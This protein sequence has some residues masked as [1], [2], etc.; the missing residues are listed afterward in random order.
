MADFTNLK[1]NIKSNIK[2]N[3]KQ[4]VTG[5]IL[6]EQMID[7]VDQMNETFTGELTELESE[8]RIDFTPV[9][10]EKIEG[11]YL[12]KGKILPELGYCYTKT[13][14]AKAGDL[15][16]CQTNPG[17]FMSAIESYIDEERTSVLSSISV[18][19]NEL[20]STYYLATQDCFVSFSG[21]TKTLIVAKSTGAYAKLAKLIHNNDDITQLVYNAV[22]IPFAITGYGI[23]NRGEIVSS[24]EEKTTG[25][26]FVG[27]ATSVVISVVYPSNNVAFYDFNKKLITL[28][29]GK[30]TRETIEVPSNAVYMAVGDL[31]SNKASEV[32]INIPSQYLDLANHSV[33]HG[34][35]RKGTIIATSTTLSVSNLDNSNPPA[36]PIANAKW[37]WQ[38]AYLK[39]N[40]AL[41]YYTDEIQTRLVPIL[42]GA[43]Y[44][45]KGRF[46]GDAAM[47]FYDENS[48]FISGISARDAGSNIITNLD[49]VTPKNAKYASFNCY[50]SSVG[51]FEVVCTETYYATGQNPLLQGSKKECGIGLVLETER[52]NK[53][54]SVKQK[55]VSNVANSDGVIELIK[56]SCDNGVAA[57]LQYR[58]SKALDKNLPQKENTDRENDIYH[59]EFPMSVFE[60]YFELKVGDEIKETWILDGMKR[61]PFIKRIPVMTIR[62]IADESNFENYRNLRLFLESNGNVV[63]RLL[64]KN[65]SNVIYQKDINTTDD[66]SILF[67][68]LR[69]ELQ[70]INGLSFDVEFG[71]IDGVSVNELVATKSAGLPFITQYSDNCKIDGTILLDN[72]PVFIEAVDNEVFEI[73][74]VQNNGQIRFFVEGDLLT[75]IN[76]EINSCEYGAEGLKVLGIDCDSY[77][78]GAYSKRPIIKGFTCHE[79]S[80]MPSSKTSDSANHVGNILYLD[81]MLRNK[82]WENISVSDVVQYMKNPNHPMPHK[83]WFIEIDDFGARQ[84]VTDI[85]SDKPE[86]MRQMELLKMK[87]IHVGYA[88]HLE[89]DA[90]LFLKI[91]NGTATDS[92]KATLT[93]YM[94]NEAVYKMRGMMN[95]MGWTMALHSLIYPVQTVTDAKFDDVIASIRNSIWWFERVYNSTP[96]SY[97]THGT[98]NSS[99]YYRRIMQMYGILCVGQ[100]NQNWYSIGRR[101][102][103]YNRVGMYNRISISDAAF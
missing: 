6:Q 69:T 74:V 78:N 35:I 30:K 59:V 49:F 103:F 5:A 91:K 28:Y 14:E 29:A 61:L 93:T 84:K 42:G 24:V 21:T 76:G 17:G 8:V 66:L 70:D 57:S 88:C 15:F 85:V 12:S 25:F 100:D 87:N 18:L 98:G 99:P 37:D 71:D 67:D 51:G 75:T 89:N 56:L 72:C 48:N 23:N 53:H 44:K 94:S 77:Y 19:G 20:K 22:N 65:G 38:A 96:L 34:F 64:I 83:C 2:S 32:L 92:E 73:E 50:K 9:S 36:K 41:T 52:G 39:T 54:I 55:L 27:N 97:V 60:H 58:F 95:S 3:G 13:I 102:A 7:I 4:E 101:Q 45:Y 31:I 90:E 47:G 46:S 16:L 26:I 10:I 82:G 1:D 63:N 62:L 68:S 81:N 43:K 79:L 11:Y 80:T 33:R 40:G 86:Y